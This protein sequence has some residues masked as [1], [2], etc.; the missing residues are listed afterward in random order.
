MIT[1]TFKK[2]YKKNIVMKLKQAVYVSVCSELFKRPNM[3]R[4][5][6]GSNYAFF[7][8]KKRYT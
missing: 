3:L 2:K 4:S 5:V 1:V 8:K 7:L 6:V